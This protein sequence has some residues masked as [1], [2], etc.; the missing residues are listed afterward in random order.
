MNKFFILILATTMSL[1]AAS[2]NVSVISPVLNTSNMHIHADGVVV[3]TN[4]IS[5]TAQTTGIIKLFIANNSN[6]KNGDK[7]A[8]IID[9]RR[10]KKLRFLKIKLQ[11]LDKQLSSQNEKL[12]DA[13]AMFTLGVGSKNSYLN[14]KVLLEQ[15]Q[16]SRQNVKIEYDTLLLEDKNSLVVAHADGFITNLLAQNSYVSYGMFLGNFS[17]KDS[18]VKLFVDGKYAKSIT[19]GVPVKLTSSYATTEG[20]VN[21]I[22]FQSSNNLLE[23]M[24]RLKTKLP[25][26]S[27]VNATI[28]LKKMDGFTIPKESVVL[29]DNHPAIYIIKDNMAH[30]VFID[31]IKDMINTVL[32]K[33]SIPIES[34]IALKNSYMLHDNLEVNIK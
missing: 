5:L 29:V 34:K 25:L 24:V 18:Q 33:K 14:E 1:F 20:V 3:P 12:H 32:I 8:K 10:E 26:N 6:V 11:L 13:K 9:D 17:T 22:L 28:S 30:L 31:I 2:V 7:I 27:N 4:K 15:I 16:A 23:V 21:N 19:K